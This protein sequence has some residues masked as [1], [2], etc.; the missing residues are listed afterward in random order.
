MKL[1]IGSNLNL[2]GA[3]SSVPSSGNIEQPMCVSV[4]LCVCA[5]A[6]TVKGGQGTQGQGESY[7]ELGTQILILRFSVSPDCPGACISI[8]HVAYIPILVL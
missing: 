5:H 4:C 2:S 8:S 6:C 7:S 3:K 1:L